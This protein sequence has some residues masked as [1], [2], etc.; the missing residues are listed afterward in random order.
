[1]ATALL[2][3]VGVD[4]K[5]FGTSKRING[6]PGNV[7]RMFARA[8]FPGLTDE[9]YRRLRAH[10]EYRIALDRYNPVPMDLRHYGLTTP[11]GGDPLMP[12]QF[13]EVLPPE[14]AYYGPL[15]LDPGKKDLLQLLGVR[16]FLTS[17]GQPLYPALKASG[18]LR[19]IKPPGSYFTVFEVLKPKPAYGWE[20]DGARDSIDKTYWSAERR[21]FTVRSEKGGRFILVEQFFP[22]WQATIDGTLV[23]IERWNHAFQSILVPAGEHRIRFTFASRGLRVGALVSA[24][25]VLALLLCCLAFGRSRS[26]SSSR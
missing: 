21:E 10:P 15:L 4:Y 20:V 18:D 9:V 26:A 23:H 11:Q 1:V 16:Y 3:A 22:G 5:V 8:V 17:E 12:A 6:N 13:H 19:P 25:S 2:L 24:G 14:G 7:D